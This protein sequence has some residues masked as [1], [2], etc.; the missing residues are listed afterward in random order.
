MEYA[1]R[2]M[3]VLTKGILAGA[4]NQEERARQPVRW[5][6]E[7]YHDDL[8]ALELR[9]LP[10]PA[11]YR[12]NY[13]HDYDITAGQNFDRIFT[14]ASGKSLGWSNGVHRLRYGYAQERMDGTHTDEFTCE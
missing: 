3:N 14:K 4:F 8:R 12:T 1:A 10:K 11:T 5:I 6:E 9:K 13:T 2:I 7:R